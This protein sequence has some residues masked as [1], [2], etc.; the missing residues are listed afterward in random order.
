MLKALSYS[1]VLIGLLMAGCASPNRPDPA[2]YETFSEYEQRDIH[3][4]LESR[5]ELALACDGNTAAVHRILS[6][7]VGYGRDGGEKGEACTIRILTLMFHL[8]DDAFSQFLQ[9]EPAETREAVGERIDW[10]F[11]RLDLAFPMTRTCYSYRD[12][13]Q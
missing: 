1:S 11:V 12:T 10:A 3:R 4:E 2:F 9:G 6:C 13:S 7:A 5:G 8:G